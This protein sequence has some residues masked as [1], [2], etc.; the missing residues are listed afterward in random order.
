MVECQKCEYMKQYMKK[1]RMDKTFRN[2]ERQNE[3]TAKRSARQN[4]LLKQNEAKI[5][6]HLFIHWKY[7][8]SVEHACCLL[9]HPIKYTNILKLV[10]QSHILFH[11]IIRKHSGFKCFMSIWL[12]LYVYYIF[13]LNLVFFFWMKF[14]YFKYK[15]HTE[16]VVALLIYLLQ[17]TIQKKSL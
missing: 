6:K 14:I 11:L 5:Y 2:I 15:F 1:R 10:K 7:N 13:I 12:Y 3:L 8:K 9:R 16:K 17:V 4:L